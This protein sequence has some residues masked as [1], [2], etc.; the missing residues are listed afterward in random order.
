MYTDSHDKILS[1]E[2]NHQNIELLEELL[3]FMIDEKI[4]NMFII[5]LFKNK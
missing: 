2:S 1:I 5:S 3:S 4:E